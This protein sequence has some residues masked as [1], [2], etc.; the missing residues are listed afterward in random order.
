M[1]SAAG[2][3]DFQPPACLGG[4][5]AGS[6]GTGESSVVSPRG[7]ALRDARGSCR[8]RREEEGVPARRREAGMAARSGCHG[9]GD[10]DTS[11]FLR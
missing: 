11:R 1:A 7:G 6:G 9:A 8:R 2:G 5:K 10:G 4:R 3:G